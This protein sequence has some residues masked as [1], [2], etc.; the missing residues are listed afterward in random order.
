MNNCERFIRGICNGDIS[1]KAEIRATYY[2][3]VRDFIALNNSINQIE[4]ETKYVYDSAIGLIN[5]RYTSK[6]KKTNFHEYIKKYNFDELFYFLVRSIYN[7]EFAIRLDYQKLKKAKIK[8]SQTISTQIYEKDFKDILKVRER[9]L[10]LIENMVKAN[11]MNDFT[12]AY[13]DLAVDIVHKSKSSSNL[14]ND[15]EIKEY[16]KDIFSEAVLKLIGLINKGNY[17]Y[18]AKV[19]SFLYWPMFNKWN[20]ISRE[21]GV[22]IDDDLLE[23]LPEEDRI[24]FESNLEREELKIFLQENIQKLNAREKQILWLKE[25]EGYSYQ[26]IK[27]KL[28]LDEE[29]NYLKQI[30]LRGKRNLQEH[31]KQDTR[32]DELFS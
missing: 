31:L 27:D 25:A 3:I 29:I 13:F 8:D 15:V 12:L 6:I 9:E 14:L 18:E 26:E 17:I 5:L 21:I 22:D 4:I 20:K 16:A 28:Q 7:S 1:I 24:Y 19:S 30:K 2:K 11:K 10:N 32:Y 23:N